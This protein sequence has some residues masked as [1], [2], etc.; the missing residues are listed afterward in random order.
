MGPGDSSIWQR[1]P[2]TP[3]LQRS[4]ET[5]LSGLRALLAIQTSCD[6]RTSFFSV[7]IELITTFFCSPFCFLGPGHVGS[8]LP[9]QDQTRTTPPPTGRLSLTPRPPV[10]RTHPQSTSS[11]DTVPPA[12]ESDR[13]TPRVDFS[14]RRTRSWAQKTPQTARSPYVTLFHVA[15]KSQ[16]VIMA[17]N[18]ITSSSIY[19]HPLVPQKP[20]S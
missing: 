16:K 19:S 15:S 1:D 9:D 14:P 18:Q 7:F 13:R 11:H 3:P 8:P 20:A 10:P 5:A 12:A 6:F 2:W 17:T 4:R